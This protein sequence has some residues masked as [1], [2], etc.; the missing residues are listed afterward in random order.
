MGK[1]RNLYGHDP[2]CCVSKGAV[3]FVNHLKN[4]MTCRCEKPSPTAGEYHQGT[5]G[6]SMHMVYG[7]PRGWSC[8]LT[9]GVMSCRG[10][11]L[12]LGVLPGV[13]GTVKHGGGGSQPA[14]AG[15]KL[16]VSPIVGRTGLQ[17]FL[18]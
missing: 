16:I 10:P 6:S 13:R 17:W 12:K 15:M 2:C 11:R 7:F 8:E 4:Y 5:M 14:G 9:C 1:V 18:C 3:D